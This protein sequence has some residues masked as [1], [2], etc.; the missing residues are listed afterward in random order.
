M[1]TDAGA[2]LL[3]FGLARRAAAP[4]D[5]RN[6]A[7]TLDSGLTEAGVR[8]GTP[9]YMAPEQILGGSVDGRSDLFSFGI[10]LTEMLTGVHPFARG[11]AA[12][13]MAA[14]LRDPPTSPSNLTESLTT[15]LAKLLAKE[16]DARTS[17]FEDVLVAL[18]A[19]SAARSRPVTTSDRIGGERRVATV[20]VASVSRATRDEGDDDEEEQ[21]RGR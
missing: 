18:C 13:T 17:S 9:A 21:L 19:K 5:Q 12:D 10:L 6:E 8:L 20:L 4:A 14:I 7:T 11:S 2:K 1:L 3:D 15:L 16:R